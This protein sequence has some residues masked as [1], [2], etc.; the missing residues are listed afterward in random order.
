MQVYI[1]Y[2]IF[3]LFS[4][5]SLYDDEGGEKF[6]STR[7]P[8]RTGPSAKDKTKKLLGL[9]TVKE[10]NEDGASVGPADSSAHI[11][12]RQ[13]EDDPRQIPDEE[14]PAAVEPE[15]DDDDEELPELSVP[16]TIGL[17]VIVTVLVAITAEWLVDSI[18]GLASSGGISKEFIGLIL[19]PIVGNAAEHATAVTVSIKDKL[20]LSLGVAVGSS[21]VSLHISDNL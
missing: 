5:K 1:S 19:L 4:H 14:R 7:Y 8:V 6:K 11:N 10:T 18:D 3:Q 15:Q 12:R 20:T 2:L 13:T 16:V 9:S 21:I 17:L